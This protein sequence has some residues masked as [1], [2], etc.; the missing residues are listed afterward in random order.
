MSVQ[1]VSS[2]SLQP[3]LFARNVSCTAL[4]A[5]TSNWGA[6]LYT[7]LKKLSRWALGSLRVAKTG[8]PKA[9]SARVS[10]SQYN[11][12]QIENAPV[13]CRQPYITG[14]VWSWAEHGRLGGPSCGVWAQHRSVAPR[15]RES[16][17]PWWPG[18]SCVV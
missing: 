14:S 4:S 3:Y 18:R 2:S 16:G 7:A 5:V 12:V 15:Q 1:Q 17:A 13:G 8:G 11:G 10:L 6:L 9:P